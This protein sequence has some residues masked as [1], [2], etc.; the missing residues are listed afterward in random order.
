MKILTDE[1]KTRI[2]ISSMVVG[3]ML[4]LAI[5]VPSPAATPDAIVAE[6]DSRASAKVLANLQKKYPRTQIRSVSRSEIKGVYEVVMGRNVAYTDKSGRYLLF[7]HL[8]DMEKQKD[9]TQPLKEDMSRIDFSSLPIADAVVIKQGTGEHKIALFSDPDCPYCRK[10]EPEL[11]KLENVTIYVFM[12]PLPNHPDARRKVEAVWCAKKEQ[13][14]SWREMMLENKDPGKRACDNPIDR[15]LKLAGK[16]GVRGTPTLFNEYGV[17]MV[18]AQPAAQFAAWLTQGKEAAMR[19]SKAE[20][21][22]P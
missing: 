16:L 2:I 19:V 15:N 1:V 8:Y 18:G 12:T 17:R 14:S 5:P 6:T 4:A 9:L 3:A 20:G 21:D 13:A 7:G 11:A 10:V 22:K